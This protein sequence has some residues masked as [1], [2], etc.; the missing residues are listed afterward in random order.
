MS[1][2]K[3]IKTGNSLAVTIPARFAKNLGLTPGMR[4]KATSN[5]IKSKITYHFVGASQL[6]LKLS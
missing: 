5:V 4:V 3:I 2:Q 1:S 6:T